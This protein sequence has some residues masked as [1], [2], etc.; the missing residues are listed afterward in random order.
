MSTQLSQ[1]VKFWS[2]ENS[3]FTRLAMV[4]LIVFVTF[5]VINDTYSFIEYGLIFLSSVGVIFLVFLSIILQLVGKRNLGFLVGIISTLTHLV[6]QG[7]LTNE[8]T[9]FTVGWD[10]VLSGEMNPIHW[11][12]IIAVA[13][14]PLS[15]IFLI[16]G[17]PEWRNLK[18]KISA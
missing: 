3:A 13:I 15:S 8:G 7:L 1:R 16:L 5:S 12:W 6:W 17:R 10:F 18:R 14:L 9:I 2:K 11:L 4:L